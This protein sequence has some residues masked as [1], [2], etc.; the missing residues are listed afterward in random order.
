MR[1]KLNAFEEINEW[2]WISVPHAL[3]WVPLLLLEIIDFHRAYNVCKQR[4]CV[5]VKIIIYDDYDTQIHSVIIGMEILWHLRVWLTC[6]QLSN[7]L[8]HY[9]QF[10][11][12]SLCVLYKELRSTS[13]NFRLIIKMGFPSEPWLSALKFKFTKFVK[14]SHQL[15]K[16]HGGASI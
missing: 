4:A 10:K 14:A 8:Q 1:T 3:S 6:T 15:R 2:V 11:Q 13:E 9:F 12:L 5:R 16:Q 7:P